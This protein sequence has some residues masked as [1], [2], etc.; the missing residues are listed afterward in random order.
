MALYAFQLDGDNAVLRWSGTN[1]QLGI[2]PGNVACT[3]AQYEEWVTKSA[4]F[5]G[6]KTWRWT[7]IDNV[8]AEVVDT[9]K[10]GTWSPDAAGSVNGDGDV[11]YDLDQDAAEP[12]VTLT[13]TPG[14]V[15]IVQI[16]EF[17]KIGP[18]KA[19]VVDGVVTLS[20]KTDVPRKFEID[21]SDLLQMANKLR[22]RVSAVKL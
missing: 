19:V 22:V 21:R 9:R 3:Q 13:V 20:I 14:A 12:T 5:L 2:P 10:V 16:V 8:L 17:N 7:F 11:E 15:N 4:L 18:V 1:E 6:S